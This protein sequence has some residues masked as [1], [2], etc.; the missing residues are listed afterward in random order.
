MLPTSRARSASALLLPALAAA[1]GSVPPEG[2]ARIERSLPE[3]ARSL[4]GGPVAR[5]TLH[6]D[7]QATV[8]LIRVAAPIARHRHR[9]SEELVYLLSGEGVLHL[10]DGDRALQAGDLVVIPVDTPHGFTPTGPEPA[11]I[12]STFVPP[13]VE[14]DRVMEEPPR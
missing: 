4:Q 5:A 9:Q 11:V 14:G 3:Q 10:R 12:L 2:E 1:C 7:E 8:Q 13:F 6:E